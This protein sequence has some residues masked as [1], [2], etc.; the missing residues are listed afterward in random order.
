MNDNYYELRHIVKS[1][2]KSLNFYFD[3]ISNFKTLEESIYEHDKI[4]LL[5]NPGIGKSTEL[6]KLFDSLWNKI[7]TNGIVPFSINLKNFRPIHNFEDLLVYENW[8]TL[9]QIIFILDGLDEISEIE[10]FLSAF[11]VFINKNKLSNY[12]YVISCRT[13]IY[14]KYL[15]NISNFE[16]F[17]LEDLSFEQSNSILKKKFNINF[18]SI[19]LQDKHYQYLK[20]PFF[21]N[22]FAEYYISEKK[23][24]DS[25]SKMWEKYVYKHLEVHKKKLQKRVILNIPQEIKD[26]KK[27]AFINEFQ[28]K[29]FITSTQLNEVIGSNYVQFIEN[30]FFVNLESEKEKFSFEHRQLQEYFVAKTLSEKSFEEILLIIKV[31]S[32]EKVPPTLFNSLSFLINLMEAGI[33][34]NKL[35]DWIEK[36]QIELLIR[37][38]SDRINDDLKI[39]VFQKYFEDICIEK[40][41]WITTD[42]TFSVNEIAK[43]GDCETNFDYLISIIKDD[44]R[45]FRAR[46]SALNLISFFKRISNKKL[47][48]FKSFLIENLISIDNSKQI[49]ASVLHCIATM[50]ICNEDENYLKNILEIFEDETNKEINIE[51]L[52]IIN[53]FDNVDIYSDYIEEEFLRENNIKSRTENDEILR[54]N[55]YVLNQLIL[56]IR[57][58][59]KFIKFAKYY[60]DSEKNIDIYTSD[61]NELIEKC[62]EFD[63]NDDEFILKLFKNLDI[64]KP[65][66][67]F[68]RPFRELISKISN[69]SIN[70]I[71]KFLIDNYDFKDIN[72]VLSYLTNDENIWYVIEKLKNTKEVEQK[73]VEYFRNFTSNIPKRELAR[74]FNN[75]MIK[76][77]FKFSEELYSDEEILK[78]QKDFENKPQKNFD[79]LF[80][81][82]K[83]L[84]EFKQIFKENQEQ[85]SQERYREINLEWY[86]KNGHANK[87]DKS[88]KILGN[89]IYK[90]KRPALFNDVEK[91]VQND[92]FIYKEIKNDLKSSDKTTHK[93]KISESQKDLIQIWVLEKIKE[94]DF[95]Q[96]FLGNS[97]GYSLLRDY[98]KWEDVVYFSRKLE[99]I[100]PQ[101]F[102]LNSLIIP[103]IRSYDEDKTWFDYF[104]E[105]ITD[106]IIFNN[107]ITENLKCISLTTFVLENH[108]NYAIEKS[109]KSAFPEIRTYLLNQKREYH[110]KK[111]LFNFYKLENDVEL[112]KE[113]CTDINTFKAWEAISILLEENLEKDFCISKA[114][115]YL[116]NLNENNKSF[117]SNSLNV[118]FQLNSIKALNYYYE[119]LNVDLNAYAYANYFSSYDAIEEYEILEK[120]FTK[121]YLD[122][123]FEKAFNNSASFLDQYISNLSKDDESYNKVQKTLLDIRDKLSTE[124]IDTGIFQINL[125][126]DNSN[127][128]YINFKSKPLSFKEAL[129]KVEGILD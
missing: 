18:E 111:Q 52:N 62:V 65:H 3:E 75:E 1:D 114:L 53:E 33:S 30:P 108:I 71:F 38:D 104:K 126:I 14:E 9:P 98:H 29:N 43:F 92:D 42:R 10:D 32:L 26:L 35:I 13:N 99:L 94:I 37:A 118:L 122:R 68:E 47:I 121:I 44:K 88:L 83:L 97:D 39:R 127:S 49:K 21:L 117:I 87:V 128:S 59:D 89:L 129:K 60:F 70:R 24:P 5:G 46:I 101:E 54:G 90:I 113:C 107:Q 78:M 25:D 31:G 15:V 120:F 125:L 103:E 56:K 6:K 20:T 123:K 67:Y 115:E 102:L 116:E 79:I 91:L 12:K 109:L 80:K 4:V 58:S 51:L 93:I 61:E 63:K 110:F 76:I 23:L 81:K 8:R 2:K 55:D 64:Q 69:N 48:W 40:T 41:Y 96:I 22:L 72:Y 95:D 66:F 85:I 57:D 124:G 50:K 119:F 100:L 16:T 74:I 17:F 19:H 7:D 34:R 84:T 77:G 45:Q 86:K 112:L 27:I 73:E 105:N 11:E 28:Q 82:N 106:E 36:N